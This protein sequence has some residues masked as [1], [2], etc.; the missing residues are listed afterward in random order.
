HGKGFAVVADE[1][2]K[3][4]E[5]SAQSASE[6]ADLV[7]TIQSETKTAVSAMQVNTEEVNKGLELSHQAGEALQRILSAF[8][9]LNDQIQ[10]VTQ[11]T[12][13]LQTAIEDVT[14]NV[15]G[16]AK[17]AQENAAAAEQMSS[18][19]EQVVLAME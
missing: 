7:V 11:V 9:G 10:S 12:V 1:V 4:A 2:R 19:S 16:I 15:D 6:I 18:Q 5:R 14:E 17:I 8:D 13:E 3:L